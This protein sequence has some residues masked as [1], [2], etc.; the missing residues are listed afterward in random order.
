[1]SEITKV[2]G[3]DAQTIRAQLNELLKVL[4]EAYTERMKKKFIA[5]LDRTDQILKMAQGDSPRRILR[6][7]KELDN[8]DR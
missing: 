1:M 4:Q 2:I 7:M 8:E 3:Q 5:D 6:R